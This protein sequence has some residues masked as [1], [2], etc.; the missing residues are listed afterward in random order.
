[1]PVISVGLSSVN[2]MC[3][4][5]TCVQDEHGSCLQVYLPTVSVQLAFD[6]V[7]SEELPGQVVMQVALIHSSDGNEM[8]ALQNSAMQVLMFT[9]DRASE[10]AVRRADTLEGVAS[11]IA[12]D[13]HTGL[14]PKGVCSET[15]CIQHVSDIWHALLLQI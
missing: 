7:L 3:C 2:S 11:M 9:I 14:Q 12:L 5:A 15:T 6:L 8:F 1:M 4:Q 13:F 10:Q